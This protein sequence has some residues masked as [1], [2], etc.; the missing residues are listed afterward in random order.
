MFRVC[1]IVGSVTDGAVAA[2]VNSTAQLRYL[3]LTRIDALATAA[4]KAVGQH[5]PNLQILNC[6]A[7]NYVTEEGLKALATGPGNSHMKVPRVAVGV[8]M[9]LM[10]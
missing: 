2:V 10:L 8:W 3:D 9:M 4:L 7:C 5:C 6:Y 1:W